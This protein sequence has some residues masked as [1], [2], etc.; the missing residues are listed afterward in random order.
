MT[1]DE[2]AAV[3]A[4]ATAL[5][6]DERSPAAP[7]PTRWDLAARVRI[8]AVWQARRIADARSRWA[9]SDRLHD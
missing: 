4:A 5:L 3:I 8:D 9:M 6:A 2:L 1:D 7:A